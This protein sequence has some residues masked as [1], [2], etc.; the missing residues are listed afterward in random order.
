MTKPVINRQQFMQML[1]KRLNVHR[2]RGYE[3]TVVLL[4]RGS[5][6]DRADCFYFDGGEK[7]GLI[8][9]EVLQDIRE[10]FTV[11]PYLP[12]GTQGGWTVR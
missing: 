9:L 1:E 4:P 10:A 2:G 12:Y 11:A 6:I 8:G 7:S 5:S 3:I